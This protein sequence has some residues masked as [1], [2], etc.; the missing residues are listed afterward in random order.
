MAQSQSIRTD[1]PLLSFSS[2]FTRIRNSNS[3]RP[4]QQLSRVT[5]NS[6]WVPSKNGGGGMKKTKSIRTCA[7]WLLNGL[8]L[9]N[10][11]PKKSLCPI[12]RRLKTWISGLFTTPAAVV[13][14]SP[15]HAPHQPSDLTLTKLIMLSIW[16]RKPKATKPVAAIVMQVM[17]NFNPEIFK[18]PMFRDVISVCICRLGGP[19]GFGQSSKTIFVTIVLTTMQTMSYPVRSLC[20]PPDI[21]LECVCQA[22][23]GFPAS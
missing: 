5:S 21:A 22:A 16:R 6:A 18:S 9:T 3:T 1:L 17:G 10:C 7:W 11:L 19:N 15:L 4:Y 23:L 12:S 14:D 2:V 8:Q 20:S 13:A